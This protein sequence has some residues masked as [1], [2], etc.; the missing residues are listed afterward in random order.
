MV[1]L[2]L[3]A[4]PAGLRG[5][6]TRWLVEVTPGVFVGRLN[7]RLRDEIWALVLEMVKDGK[8]IMVFSARNSEQGFAFRTHRHDW[9]VEDF[10]GL[11]VVRRPREPR[12][13]SLRKG[14]S[15]AAHRRRQRRS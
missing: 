5:Q 8:A 6:L 14:W 3:T 9:Q 15:T 13:T 11:E 1:T 10:D 12:P 2:V 4:C 7:A